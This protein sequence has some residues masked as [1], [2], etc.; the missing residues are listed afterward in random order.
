M[1]N[2]L[3]YPLDLLSTRLQTQ[4]KGKSSKCE[5]ASK[6]VGGWELKRGHPA[7]LW[8]A[9]MRQEGHMSL[10]EH[11]ASRCKEGDRICPPTL[12]MHCS[13]LLRFVIS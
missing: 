1:S 12:R 13:H 2:S 6:W 4:S 9:R 5:C 8:S 11:G 10:Y 7:V 3:V